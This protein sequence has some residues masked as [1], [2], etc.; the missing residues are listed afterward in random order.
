M[1]IAWVI[2]MFEQLQQRVAKHL[3]K[4]HSFMC[5]QLAFWPTMA[6]VA[7]NPWIEGIMYGIFIGLVVYF[8]IAIK[9][10]INYQGVRNL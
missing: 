10:I 6:M 4:Q 9:G 8:C 1:Y 3:Q 7:D 2:D 5:S